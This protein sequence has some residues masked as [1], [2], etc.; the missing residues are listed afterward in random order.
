MFRNNKGIF[1]EK[2]DKV[3]RTDYG[4]YESLLVGGIHEY[5]VEFIFSRELRNNPLGYILAENG[6]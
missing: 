3:F 1:V 2:V 6:R 4:F 5:K